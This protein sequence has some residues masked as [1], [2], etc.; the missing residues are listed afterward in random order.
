M[1]TSHLKP[2]GLKMKPTS[3]HR[4]KTKITTNFHP[5]Q[6]RTIKEECSERANQQPAVNPRINPIKTTWMKRWSRRTKT[7]VLSWHYSA[8]SL[9]DKLVSATV[10]QLSL[11][12]MPTSEN[13]SATMYRTLQDLS[14]AAWR[15]VGITR[16][17]RS[18]CGSRVAMLTQASTASSRTES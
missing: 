15:S 7:V 12:V 13:L 8:L 2:Q 3:K 9:G 5:N 6:F 4:K 16:V 1:N 17:S 18:S 10:W 14:S 11:C